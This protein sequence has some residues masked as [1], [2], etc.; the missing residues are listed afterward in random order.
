MRLRAEVKPMNAGDEA[1]TSAAFV[2]HTVA[3]Q[4]AG[5]WCA[6]ILSGCQGGSV[7]PVDCRSGLVVIGAVADARQVPFPAFGAPIIIRD[8]QNIASKAS[9]IGLCQSPKYGA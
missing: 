3:S 4:R 8:P 1:S 7:R 6:W 9:C 5:S 2:W